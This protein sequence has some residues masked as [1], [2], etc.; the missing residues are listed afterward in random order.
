MRNQKLLGHNKVLRIC[1]MQVTYICIHFLDNISKDF[2]FQKNKNQTYHHHLLH[3]TVVDFRFF[4]LVV[5]LTSI[6][7][8]VIRVSSSTRNVFPINLITFEFFII[9]KPKLIIFAVCT[10]TEKKKLK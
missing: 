6:D 10:L 7:V 9:R 1:L 5:S 3:S 2:K 4:T 8:Y